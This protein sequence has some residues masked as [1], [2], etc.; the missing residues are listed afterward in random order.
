MS[1]AAK[2]LMD[3]VWVNVVDG[4][5]GSDNATLSDG[6]PEGCSACK[7]LEDSLRPL[8]KFVPAAKI[9]QS[10]QI[11]ESYSFIFLSLPDLHNWL[12]TS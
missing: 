3:I 2:G 6:S 12:A 7:G 9:L 8:I 11:A 1:I 5:T 4:A 10:N